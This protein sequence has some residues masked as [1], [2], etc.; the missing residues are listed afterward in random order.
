[1]TWEEFQEVFNEKYFNDA[2]RRAKVEE[3]ASLVQGRLSVTE[4]AQTLDILARFVPE[5]VPT[6]RAC[7]DKFIRGLDSMVAR[8]VKITMDLTGTTYT[9]VVERALIAEGT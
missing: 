4:Y 8:D 6:D 1:M 9:Q 2:V 7:R 3:F 5:L